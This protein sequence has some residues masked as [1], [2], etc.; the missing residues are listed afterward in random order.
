MLTACS[1][2]PKYRAQQAW[3]RT[4]RTFV[5]IKLAHWG[6]QGDKMSADA[7]TQEVR[8]RYPEVPF[9]NGRIVDDWGHPIRITITHTVNDAWGRPI[10][11]S[12][13]RAYRGINLHLRSAGPDGIEQTADDIISEVQS[14]THGPCP[15]MPAPA[16]AH[17]F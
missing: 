8:Q 15:P 2:S 9:I 16:N 1:L 4:Y 11:P 5:R 14:Y 7:V 6:T 12:T 3:K 10:R 17:A 13:P